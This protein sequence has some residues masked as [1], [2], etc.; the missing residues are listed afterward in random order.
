MTT[1]VLLADV[2]E[3]R[4]HTF[5]ELA[6]IW[7]DIRND[8]EDAGGEVHDS[9]VLIGDYDLQVVFDA[10]DEETVLEV[11]MAVQRHGLN[12]KT[13]RAVPMAQIGEYATD[14]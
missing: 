11:S 6:S 14:P 10:D 12:T 2:N 13:M 3:Q 1:H 4:F 5:Q 9:N 7:G 8:I